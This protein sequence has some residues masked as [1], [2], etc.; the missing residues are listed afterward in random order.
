MHSVPHI[1]EI[2]ALLSPLTWAVAVI[3]FRVAGRS[4]PPLALN[5]CKNSVALPLF[6]LT[7]LALGATAPDSVNRTDLVLLL[8]SGALGIAVADTLFFM[9]L[10]RLGAS[11]QA[12]VNTAYSPPIILLS[13]IFLGETLTAIQVIGVCLILA[14]VVVVARE[15]SGGPGQA[16]GSNVTG[17]LF[18][19]A[20]CV[21]QAISIVMIKPSMGDWP[22]LWMTCWR[23]AGGLGAAVLF[24]PLLPKSK[25]SFGALADR[26]SWPTVLAGALV[27]TYMSLLLWMGGF[28]YSTA[29]V[30]SA[31]NQT[32]SLFTFA[33]AVWILRE[34]TTRRALAGLGLGL[35]G[36]AVVVAAS[37]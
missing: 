8:S 18:G 3:L 10:N 37:L 21:A 36:V 5:L 24:W 11:R 34:P 12:I 33:L 1:G 7:Y 16:P 29:S 22:L 6:F 17:V 4:V 23:M 35:A 26:K 31:L 20:A 13:V 28:K 25:R 32:S 14:A 2:C 27:G 9:C 15:T 19:V 30:A